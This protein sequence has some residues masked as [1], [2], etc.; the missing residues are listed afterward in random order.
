MAYGLDL[1]VLQYNRIK[2][3]DGYYSNYSPIY[4]EK[5]ENLIASALEENDQIAE[6]WKNRMVL[7][8]IFILPNGIIREIIQLGK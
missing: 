3:F 4:K 6:Y 5:W 1:A 2:T 8:H 7:G